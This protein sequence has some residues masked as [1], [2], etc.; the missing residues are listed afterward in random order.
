[1]V[2]IIKLQI[3]VSIKNYDIYYKITNYWYSLENYKLLYQLKIMIFII[4][5]QIIGIHYKIINYWYSLENYKL[6]YQL[7]IIA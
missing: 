2:F 7:K 3:I 1:M 6:L 5:L 4:K